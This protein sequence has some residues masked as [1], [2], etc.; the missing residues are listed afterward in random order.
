MTVTLKLPDDLGRAAEDRAVRSAKSLSVWITDLVAR[1]VRPKAGVAAATLLEALGDET[2]ADRD[3][4]LPEFCHA[5]DR[6]IEF[7]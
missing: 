2:L 3:L 5:P 4:G 1:E 6:K 7:P